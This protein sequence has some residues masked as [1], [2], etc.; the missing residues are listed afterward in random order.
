M[1][2]SCAATGAA[3]TNTSVSTSADT[4]AARASAAGISAEVAG[5][6]CDRLMLVIGPL[7]RPTRIDSASVML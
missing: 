6:L 2:K 7:V 3:A 5:N 1:S 4:S